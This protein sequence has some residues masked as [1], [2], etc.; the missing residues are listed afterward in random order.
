MRILS[1]VGDDLS[2]QRAVL[3]DMDGLK[4]L[5]SLASP[6]AEFPFVTPI[7][8]ADCACYLTNLGLSDAISA[9]AH[10]RRYHTA[11]QDICIFLQRQRV[12]QGIGH[13]CP[14]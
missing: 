6:A 2:P 12:R 5:Q 8:H 3:S 11:P 1:L 10:I 7:L 13:L 14:S 9:S 4:C